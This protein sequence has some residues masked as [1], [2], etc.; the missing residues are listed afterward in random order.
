MHPSPTICAPRPVVL[1]DGAYSGS[2]QLADLVDVAILVEAH[3]DEREAR[4]RAR[5]E[6]AFLDAWHAR[7]DAVEG[8]YASVVRPRETFDL[9]VACGEGWRRDAPA[10]TER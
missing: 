7:W 6:A 2:P 8:H 10:S 5:E 4:L 1:V 3:V 9:V